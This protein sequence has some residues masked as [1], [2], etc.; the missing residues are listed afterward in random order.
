[1]LTIG[2]AAD[3]P[4]VRDGL[5]ALLEVSLP[6]AVVGNA[7]G[8][9]E[10]A[11]LAQRLQPDVLVVDQGL[12]PDAELQ[13]IGRV[14]RKQPRIRI[15]VLGMG[16]QATDVRAALHAGVLASVLKETAAAELPTAIQRAAVGQRYLSP[17]L[18]EPAS[19]SERGGTRR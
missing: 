8:A 14:H 9:G 15:V 3:H 16:V 7:A 6:C 12:H 2:I 11:A 19:A 5:Q 4:A 10:V 13:L 1:M 18:A 17:P